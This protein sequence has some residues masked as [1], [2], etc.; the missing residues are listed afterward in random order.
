MDDLFNLVP[1]DAAQIIVVVATGLTLALPLLEFIA[2]K[3][4][5]V[6]DNQA[7][8]ILK[9]VLGFIPRVRLGKEVTK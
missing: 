5:N 1:P 7:V 4:S 2:N 6:V 8:E 9:K 3:T